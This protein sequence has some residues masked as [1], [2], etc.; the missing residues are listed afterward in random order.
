MLLKNADI[1]SKDIEELEK[2]SQSAPQAQQV[3]IKQEIL[4]IQAGVKGEQEAAYHLNF[5]YKDSEKYIILHDLRLEIG[6]R[7]A[8][9]DHLLISRFLDC[10]VFESKHFHS[11][12]KISEEGEFLRW[13]DY[14]HRFEGMSSPIAQNERHIEVLKDAFKQIEM[15]TRLGFRLS[16]SFHSYVLVS[17]NARIDRPKGFDT[18]NV[19]KA[20]VIKQTIQK[21]FEKESA[22][23]T[24]A[25]IAKVIEPTT[26]YD[27]GKK[28]AAL[29]KPLK[30]DWSKHFGFNGIERTVP[31]STGPLPQEAKVKG[32]VCKKCG[33]TSGSILYGQY[34][35]Y[36][37]CADCSGNTSIRVDCGNAGHKARVRKDGKT[38]YL[39]CEACG[40]SGVYHVNPD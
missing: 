7:V 37:K 30:T 39:E 28:L 17:S 33:S 38:F 4:M 24:W 14:K 35:Y 9:I 25:S 29:H 6:G 16:P 11:G 36:L 26:L 20:D 27:I 23:A 18:S 10:F 34:G 15:P 5:T 32:P 3:R 1:K 40:S 12:I 31:A 22:S 8:Q 13:N 19:V 21:H 2:I